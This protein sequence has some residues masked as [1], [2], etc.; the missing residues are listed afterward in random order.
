VGGGIVG[1]DGG[2][3]GAKGDV[4]AGQQAEQRRAAAGLGDDPPAVADDG[5]DGLDR[6]QKALFHAALSLPLAVVP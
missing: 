4:K 5:L 6:G 3:L 2:K 1:D